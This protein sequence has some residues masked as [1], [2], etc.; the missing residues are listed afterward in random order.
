MRA[1]AVA[2]GKQV[3]AGE[4]NESGKRAR[5]FKIFTDSHWKTRFIHPSKIFYFTEEND[6]V[7]WEYF[8]WDN[9][10]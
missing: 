7:A 8:L 5:S 2:F 4:N 10:T 9:Y 6:I 3:H 1:L